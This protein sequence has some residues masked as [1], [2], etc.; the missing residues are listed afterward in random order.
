MNFLAMLNIAIVYRVAK[1]SIK[2]RL[3]LFSKYPTREN[4]TGLKYNSKPAN[5]INASNIIL[6]NKTENVTNSKTDVW[7]SLST[8]VNFAS[9]S[10]FKNSLLR[11]D[12]TQ[13]LKC[14]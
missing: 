12:L 3:R 2:T 7:N 5:I 14:T 8:S 13:F 1:Y 9:L 6:Y 11:I 4:N 10:C